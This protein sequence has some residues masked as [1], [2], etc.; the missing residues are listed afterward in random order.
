M[1]GIPDSLKRLSEDAS[2]HFVQWLTT[3]TQKHVVR[4]QVCLHTMRTFIA[5]P[6]GPMLI[7]FVVDSAPHGSQSWHLLT[8]TS[9]SGIEL[10]RAAPPP[11][12]Q[13]YPSVASAI[14][15]LFRTVSNTQLRSALSV[16]T[17]L[18]PS[19]V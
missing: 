18:S 8:F 13:A 10:L 2:L 7:Q 11:T 5:G 16:V 4:W 12:D 19:H 17:S 1:I 9:A 14:D 6:H 15:L 3:C